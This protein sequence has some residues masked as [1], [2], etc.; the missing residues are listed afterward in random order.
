[1]FSQKENIMCKLKNSIYELKQ[2]SRQWYLKFNDI[3][4]SYDFVENIVDRCIY[5]KV[6]KSKFEI[7]VLYVDDVLLATN[8]I[9]MLHD[10][11]NFLSNNFKIKDIGKCCCCF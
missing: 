10:V 1:M 8:N 4:T 6:S 2:T 9:A 3:I 5:M 7:L 11:K